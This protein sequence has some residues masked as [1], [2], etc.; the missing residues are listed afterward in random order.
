MNFIPVGRVVSAHG[1]R[2]EIR[3]RYYNEGAPASLQ[4]PSFFV[5]DNGTKRELKPLQVRLRGD[6]FIIKFK[7]LETEEDARFLFKRE[8]FVREEDLA[9]LGEDEYYDYRLIGLTVITE[10]DREV[11][12][13]VDVMHTK[14]GDILVIGGA[15]EVLVPMTGDHI[16]AVSMEDGLVRVRESG[17]VE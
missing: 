15:R 13:V 4:Y 14:A 17:L 12:T 10:Q 11:G 8:L 16:L 2:G 9:P 5:D 6:L 7:G 3:F 1:V